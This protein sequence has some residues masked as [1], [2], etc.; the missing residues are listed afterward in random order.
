M[1]AA[2]VGAGWIVRQPGHRA[3]AVSPA[4]LRELRSILGDQIAG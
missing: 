3:V 4:G 2:F 1:L